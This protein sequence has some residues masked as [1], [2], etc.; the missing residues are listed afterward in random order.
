M[1]LL[2]KLEMPQLYIAMYMYGGLKK[3]PL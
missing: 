3:P 1:Y 2:Y